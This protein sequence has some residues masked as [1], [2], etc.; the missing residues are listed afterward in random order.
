MAG[1]CRVILRPISTGV[2]THNIQCSEMEGDRIP[3]YGRRDYS[4]V[5]VGLVEA[6]GGLIIFSRSCEARYRGEADIYILLLSPLTPLRS[7]SIKITDPSQ[8]NF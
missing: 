8:A 5:V 4:S 2:T 1:G 7:I 6:V 3:E